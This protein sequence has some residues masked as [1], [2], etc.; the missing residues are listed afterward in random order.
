MEAG[1]AKQ[2]GADMIDDS[3]TAA[4]A[5]IKQALRHAVGRCVMI[6]RNLNADTHGFERGTDCAQQIQAESE[7][8][9]NEA[10]AIVW[11]S[12]E[13]GRQAL[14]DAIAVVETSIAALT[15]E[16]MLKPADLQQPYGFEHGLVK[17]A[18]DK[19]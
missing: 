3:T 14:S 9:I 15:K 13:E 11:C 18:T 4:T 16:R 8:I 7:A 1:Q 5:I 2:T 19:G 17:Q 12:T 10:F 6:C